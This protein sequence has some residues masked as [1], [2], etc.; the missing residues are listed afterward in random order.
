[1]THFSTDDDEVKAT[2]VKRFHRTIRDKMYCF[3]TKHQTRR[4]IDALI[5]IVR[6]YNDSK[7]ESIG[8]ASNAVNN[9]TQKLAMLRNWDLQATRF[10]R[11][12]PTKLTIRDYVHFTRTRMP[13]TRGYMPRL[14]HE[15]FVVNSTESEA[16]PIAYQVED[17]VFALLRG[18][19]YEVELPKVD[20]PDVYLIEEILK[21][22]TVRPEGTKRLYVK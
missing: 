10:S 21:K 4:D 11:A 20:N 9:K 15:I 16:S 2:M 12:K 1:M 7:R 6:G 14:A 13:F 19:F 8:M 17:Q 18:L 3:L 22:Q 5:E